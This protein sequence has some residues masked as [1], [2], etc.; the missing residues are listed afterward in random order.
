M[1]VMLTG[2]HPFDLEGTG[3]NYDM[4]NKIISYEQRLPIRNCKYTTHL[5]EDAIT[6]LERLMERLSFLLDRSLAGILFLAS[7]AIFS[8]SCRDPLRRMTADELL[9]H[10]WIKGE[11]ASSRVISGSDR[12]LKT[13]LRHKTKV[14]STIFKGLLSNS[15]KHGGSELSKRISVLEMAFRDLDPKNRGY[16][17]TKELNGVTSF[18]AADAKLSLN[19]L[20]HLLRDNMEP[21]Y[22]SKGKVIYN[23][24]SKGDSM[25]F[26]QSGSVEV[27]S[28]S[29][30]FKTV[31]QCG[32][33]FGEDALMAG[34]AGEYSHTA[35]CLTPV[36]VL[37]ISRDCFEK[38][39]QADEEVEMTMAETDRKRQRE[40]AKVILGLQDSLKPLECE[41]G[42]VIF[43]EGSDGDLLYILDGGKVD[44]SVNG[45]K[46]RSLRIGEMTGEHAAFY[47]HK[48]YNVTAQ[49]VSP[50]GC[51]MQILDGN[52]IRTMC[53]NNKDL[54]DSFRDIILRRDFK[55]ALVKVTN[56]DFPETE[57]E[58]RAAF[59][60]I[61]TNKSGKI[62]FET[63]KDAVLQWD[64]SYTED[65]IRGMLRSLDI[66]NHG[67]LTWVEFRRIFSMFNDM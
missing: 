4:E 18:L 61:D 35:R 8:F 58:L 20:Q 64:G 29:D 37:K 42:Q 28:K 2:T 60:T 7:N 13:Y 48:A 11:T 15:D 55:K 23:E 30:G 49:C 66:K 21:L 19:E 62:E 24:G 12:R 27:A 25:Y 3:S 56:R 38:Y 26:L 41:P 59:D 36:H 40:R 63:L 44:I 50:E 54:H 32:E 17:S 46:V 22:F 31:R 51:T 67:H 57:E 65:D 1:Y 47:A 43:R 14:A 45:R 53:K 33:F 39:L 5:S 9:Q 6:L 34:D 10:P 52:K 16:I